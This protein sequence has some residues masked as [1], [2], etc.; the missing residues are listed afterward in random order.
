MSWPPTVTI[1]PDVWFVLRRQRGA[2]KQRERAHRGAGLTPGYHDRIYE[3]TLKPASNS[4]TID[5]SVELQN[6]SGEL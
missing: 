1:F 4:P 3:V 5:R 6:V 2:T